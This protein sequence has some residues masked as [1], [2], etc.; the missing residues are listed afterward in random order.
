VAGVWHAW[1][2]P[3]GNETIAMAMLTVNTDEHPVMNRPHKPSDEKRL[4]VIHEAEEYDEWLHTESADSA[5]SMLQQRAVAVMQ[6]NQ[7]L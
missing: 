4:V 2:E 7:M 3:G 1:R 6:L 5:R